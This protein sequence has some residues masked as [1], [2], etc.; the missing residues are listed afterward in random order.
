VSEQQA[1]GTDLLGVLA[2]EARGEQIRRVGVRILV[3]MRRLR[4]E[5]IRALRQPGDAGARAGV[6]G[7]GE[8][9]IRGG[10]ADARVG[11]EV[12]QQVHL[13]RERADAQALTRPERAEVVRRRRHARPVEREY[14][15]QRPVRGVHRQRRG[16]NV[17]QPPCT[18]Q[19]VE[20]GAVVRVPVAG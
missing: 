9:G 6:T 18:R 19:G 2:Q 11:H 7:V 1:S 13:G 16:R 3:H 5:Q 14:G 20:I 4:Q 15:V 10:Q 17:T 8:H 12:R